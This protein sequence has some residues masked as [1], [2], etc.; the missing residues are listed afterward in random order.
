MSLIN[1]ALRKAQ[2]DRTPERI[3]TDDSKPGGPAN[4][5]YQTASGGNGFSPALMIGLA[6]AVA[7]LIGLVV[8]LGIVVLKGDPAQKPAVQASA[9]SS[10]ETPDSRRPL[11]TTP[12]DREVATPQIAPP[13]SSR[14]GA[15]TT[16]SNIVEELRLAREAAEA[17]AQV[18]AQAAAE[19]AA[20]AKAATAEAKERA[21]AAPSQAVIDWLGASKISGVRLAGSDSRVI[22]NG[23]AFSVGDVV[24][25]N[26]GLKVLI[27]QEA[28]VLFEDSN[29]KR[30]MKRL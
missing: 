9:A 26:L 4:P 30:Y 18:E 23:D 7:V 19:A 8:G 28:R 10:P 12:A 22:L 1:Q 5:G 29:G 15:G 21:E 25:F 11:T 24:N 16:G 17:K 3:P 2:R 27:V 6:L 14:A 13:A 20:A